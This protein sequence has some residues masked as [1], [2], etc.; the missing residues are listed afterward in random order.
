MQRLKDAGYDAQMV[1]NDDKNMYR[2]IA[3]TFAD[4]AEA[5][6]YRD[7]LIAKDPEKYKG[8]WLLYNAR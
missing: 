8:A 4:K 2:V 6:A 3:A 7:K 1:K 5:A